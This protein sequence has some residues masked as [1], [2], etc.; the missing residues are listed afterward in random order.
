MNYG[1]PCSIGTIT[2]NSITILI[3][4]GIYLLGEALPIVLVIDFSF[5]KYFIG[6]EKI[7]NFELNASIALKQSEIGSSLLDVNISKSFQNVHMSI[8]LQDIMNVVS[9][10]ILPPNS[11]DL[12]ETVGK[13]KNGLG[14][15]VK[16]SLKQ[17]PDKVYSCRV[18]EL[19]K[20]STYLKDDVLREYYL[21]KTKITSSVVSVVEIEFVYFDATRILLFYKYFE[22]SLHS[23]IALKKPFNKEQIL[24]Y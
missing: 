18:I 15:I 12:L 2:N 14:Y 19:P 11:F 9:P 6:E 20:V 7:I 23:L 16:A 4:V 1:N 8:P 17:F 22:Y 3:G 5:M 13:R 10:F 21:Y 24:K